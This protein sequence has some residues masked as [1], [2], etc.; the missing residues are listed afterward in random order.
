LGEEVENAISH[1]VRKV[2]NSDPE[3][4]GTGPAQILIVLLTRLNRYE[5]AVEISLQYLAD[6]DQNQLACPSVLELCYLAGDSEKMKEIAKKKQD[7][8]GFTAG[9]LA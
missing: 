4:I 3:E 9:L 6:S 1:F 2:E 8:L 7:L 5:Q